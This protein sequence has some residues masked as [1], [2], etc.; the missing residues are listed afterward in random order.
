MHSLHKKRV[1]SAYWSPY[2]IVL[3]VLFATVLSCGK[4]FGAQ[5]TWSDFREPLTGKY[6]ACLNGEATE[7]TVDL[8]ADFIRAKGKIKLS[9]EFRSNTYSSVNAVSKKAGFASTSP[10]VKVN[11][12]MFKGYKK[13][14]VDDYPASQQKTLELDSDW[15]KPGRNIIKLGF[16]H[17]TRDDSCT[18]SC[19]PMYYTKVSFP[20][21]VRKTYAVTITSTPSGGDVYIN[22]KQS[23]T[24]PLTTKLKPG[25]YHVEVKKSGFKNM[26]KIK[27]IQKNNLSFS[28]DLAP[29]PQLVS[30]FGSPGQVELYI[31]N[32][33]KGTL[34][35]GLELDVGEYEFE[36]RKKGYKSKRERVVISAQTKRINRSLEQVEVMPDKPDRQAQNVQVALTPTA[37]APEVQPE[38]VKPPP[39]KPRKKVDGYAE[40]VALVIGNSN[41]RTAKLANPVND[42]TD[43]SAVL[44]DLN[45]DVITVT[46]ANKRQ[47][48]KALDQFAQKLRKADFGLFYFAGHGMQINN[49]NYLIPLKATVQ[50]E[51]DVE[52]EAV[53][54]GRILGRMRLAGNKLNVV[55]LDACR[56]NPFARTFR[57]STRGLARMDAPIGTI[58]AYATSPGS[59]AADGKGRNGVY[60]KH[61]LSALK[62]P[63]LDIQDIFNEAGRGVMAET[64]NQQIPWSSNT[65]LPQYFLIKE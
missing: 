16:K 15:F 1:N 45:F 65:P 4:T 22:S 20:Q 10:Y 61:L 36:F 18:D 53:D 56:N 12:S 40:R 47:M 14:Q 55:I 44:T 64:D 21:A 57:T 41:Y 52:F 63:N 26:A 48:I 23:G 29:K 38:K 37:T 34:P 32:A 39:A 49:R 42:A 51:S 17:D 13:L 28:F 7:V 27:K 43:I 6:K 59:V 46:D 58:V 3:L 5:T 35:L 54:A 9:L 11:K 8:P 50:A 2:L 25:E 60:T 24:T 33:Y 30:I 62:K 31:D 19:C